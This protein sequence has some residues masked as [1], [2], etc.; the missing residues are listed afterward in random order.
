MSAAVLNLI[1]LTLFDQGASHRRAIHMIT[2][3]TN[4]LFFFI[5]RGLSFRSLSFRGLSSR[6]LSFQGLRSEFSGSEFS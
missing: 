6:G 5:L 2:L 3:E 1:C 4:F